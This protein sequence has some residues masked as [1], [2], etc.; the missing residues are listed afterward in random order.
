MLRR[1]KKNKLF[2]VAPIEWRTIGVD[3]LV[4]SMNGLNGRDAG[5]VCDQQQN[6]GVG[7]AMTPAVANVRNYKRGS[8]D[9]DEDEPT[10][11]NCKR[12]REETD[13]DSKGSPISEVELDSN[14]NKSDQFSLD[15]WK[16]DDNL[17]PG[18]SIRYTSP[19]F[20][21]GNRYGARQAKILSVDPNA[22]YKL[23]L[24]NSE[25]LPDDT[26]VLLDRTGTEATIESFY[27]KQGQLYGPVDVA[28][29]IRS[30]ASA[31]KEL[32]E[33]GK[34]DL[35]NFQRRDSPVH[36]THVQNDPLVKG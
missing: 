4:P 15:R 13:D 7:L 29:G 27:L 25:L 30:R 22:E 33:N 18:D 36:S 6:R 32:M 19:I 12:A 9:T 23:T 26:F 20:V 1:R 11:K 14:D 31:I 5:N 21:S 34:R 16:V 35:F 8:E 17:L 10:M 2:Q 28:D 3:Y 24:D